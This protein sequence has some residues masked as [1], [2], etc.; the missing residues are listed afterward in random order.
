MQNDKCVPTT[1]TN[2]TTGVLYAVGSALAFGCMPIFAKIAYEGG[3]NTTTVVFLRYFI[4]LIFVS[5][6]LFIKKID[7][8]IEAKNL[9][10]TIWIG[11]VGYFITGLTLFMSYNYISV[12]LATMLHF[13]YPAI[14]MIFSRI[15]FKESLNS[16]KILALILSIVGIYILIGFS[17]CN[18]SIVGVLLA[19]ASGLSYASAV[20]GVNDSGI[21]SINYLVFTFYIYIFSSLTSLIYGLSTKQLNFHM[22]FTS[23]IS[24]VV[25]AFVCT[26]LSVIFV[27]LSVRIIG[28]TNVS[29]LSTLEPI[30]S[31][32]LGILIFRESFTIS[33]TIGGLFILSSLYLVNKSLSKKEKRQRS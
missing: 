32:I 5:V 12:G 8:K 9:Y 17:E 29:I 11:I 27:T 6:V 14:V 16:N 19:L 1:S 18:L 7:I 25:I 20:L 31:V 10:K 4:A 15:I 22:N 2:T 28:P 30:T 33:I 24:I 3:A 23:I 13:I 26:F 21:K